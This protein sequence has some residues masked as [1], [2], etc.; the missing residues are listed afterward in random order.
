MGSRDGEPGGAGWA[1]GGM[2]A[3]KGYAS[4]PVCNISYAA[5]RL[6]N[7]TFHNVVGHAL[8]QVQVAKGA[9]PVLRRLCSWQHGIQAVVRRGRQLQGCLHQGMIHMVV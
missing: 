4:S 3:V 1:P 2:G 5:R 8:P 7:L 9:G 6:R